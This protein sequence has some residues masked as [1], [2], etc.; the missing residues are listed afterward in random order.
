VAAI[1]MKSKPFLD[2]TKNVYASPVPS[3]A[4]ESGLNTAEQNKLPKRRK[5]K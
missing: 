3:A 1:E 5:F 4:G 2:I